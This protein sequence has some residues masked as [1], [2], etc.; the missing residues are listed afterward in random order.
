MIRK[1]RVYGMFISE[2]LEV[3]FKWLRLVLIQIFKRL[4]EELHWAQEYWL[5]LCVVSLLKMETHIMSSRL[6][7]CIRLTICYSE[8][9]LTEQKTDLQ[10]LILDMKLPD[11]FQTFS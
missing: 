9:T 5:L 10:D 3:S 4:N 1:L 6:Y 8:A 11:V 2:K 7:T